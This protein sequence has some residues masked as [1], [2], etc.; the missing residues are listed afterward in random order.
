MKSSRIAQFARILIIGLMPLMLIA[1][2]PSKAEILRQMKQFN[3]SDA[4]TAQAV[5]NDIPIATILT[6]RKLQDAAF[7][8]AVYIAVIN[9]RGVYT[10]AQIAELIDLKQSG[11]A[12]NLI[13]SALPTGTSA[14]A[15]PQA[16]KSEAPSTKRGLDYYTQGTPAQAGAMLFPEDQHNVTLSVLGELD[17]EGVSEDMETYGGGF[18]WVGSHQKSATKGFASTM[19]L[20][21]FGFTADN[22]ESEILVGNVYFSNSFYLANGIKKDIA[23]EVVSR[24]FS[25]SVGPLYGVGAT[26]ISSTLNIDDDNFRFSSS[27]F[28]GIFSGLLGGRVATEIPIIP[29]MLYAQGNADLMMSYQTGEITT[30]TSTRT[31]TMTSSDELTTDISENYFTPAYSYDLVLYPSQSFPKIKFTLGALLQLTSDEDGFTMYTF[32]ITWSMGPLYTSRSVSGSVN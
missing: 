26:I 29:G 8:D 3:F 24:G 10:T 23:G 1:Q 18:R 19:S 14:A 16:L 28:G 4:V 21:R 27:T 31:S 12:D 20:M 25:L 22:F 13:I 32:G 15:Q 2:A 9:N 11:F 30:N 7:G 5:S 6:L 17:M